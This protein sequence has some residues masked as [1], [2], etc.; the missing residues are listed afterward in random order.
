MLLVVVDSH[1]RVSVLAVLLPPHL[2]LHQSGCCWVHLPMIVRVLV[3]VTQ[4][5]QQQQ[6]DERADEQADSR[7]QVPV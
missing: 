3:A 6:V 2:S 4:R 7:E 1:E 5:Q